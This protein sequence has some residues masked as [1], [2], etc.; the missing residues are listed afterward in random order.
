MNSKIKSM[1]INFC[2]M[3]G[4]VQKEFILS[5]KTVNSATTVKLYEY[6]VQV[7]EDFA[8]NFGDKYWLLHHDNA[9]SHTSFFTGELST[10]SNMTAVFNQPYSSLFLRL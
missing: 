4:I 10:K 1:L 2:D 7:C 9:P 5:G 8:P 6:C 3:K